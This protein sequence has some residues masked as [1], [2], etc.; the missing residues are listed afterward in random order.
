MI[1][2][3]TWIAIIVLYGFTLAFAIWIIVAG[4]Q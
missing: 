2:I 1:K 4:I 3:L